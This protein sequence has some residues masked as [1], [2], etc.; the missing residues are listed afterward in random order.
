MTIETQMGCQGDTLRIGVHWF[1]HNNVDRL[2]VVEIKIEAQ[3][4]P[5]TLAVGV[6]TGIE[7]IRINPDG[8]RGLTTVYRYNADAEVTGQA[9]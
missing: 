3:D 9:F 4:K 1:D 7:N 5:R 2:T 6:K 8:V